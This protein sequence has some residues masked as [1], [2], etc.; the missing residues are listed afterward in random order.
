MFERL[1]RYAPY[2]LAI[3]RI[4]TGTLMASHGSQKVLGWFGGM[5]PGVPPYITWGAGLIELIGGALVAIGLLTRPAAFLVSG[6][7]AFAYFIGHAPQGFW[8][9]VNQGE[10]AVVY[11]WL[12]L[13]FAAQGPGAWAVDALANRKRA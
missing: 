11:C 9:N 4:L 10:L 5:P 3:L 12:F 8:P 7:M 6:L 1:G 13:Y 2:I